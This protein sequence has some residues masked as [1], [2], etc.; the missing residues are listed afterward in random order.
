MKY[1]LK[2]SIKFERC[3]HLI[4]WTSISIKQKSGYKFYISPEIAFIIG[5]L[6]IKKIIL[7]DLRIPILF[8]QSEQQVSIFEF[9]ESTL[10]V[11]Y[12]SKELKMKF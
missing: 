7:S 4:F 8:A 10:S 11:H 1:I 5:N 12:L 3:S 6:M 9:V 2:L